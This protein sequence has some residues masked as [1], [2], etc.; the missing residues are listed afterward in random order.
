MQDKDIEKDLSFKQGAL[1]SCIE[2]FVSLLTFYFP[3][4]TLFWIIRINVILHISRRSDLLLLDLIKVFAQNRE[5]Q[6]AY[7]EEF[8]IWAV[9]GD[10]ALWEFK[11]SEDGLL[12]RTQVEVKWG[13]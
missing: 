12:E 7:G 8:D 3:N 13:S 11:F 6:L 1:W 10:V 2:V 5:V 4:Q 9:G